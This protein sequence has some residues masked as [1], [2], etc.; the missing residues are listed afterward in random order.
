MAAKHDVQNVAHSSANFWAIIVKLHA[1]KP[2]KF[3]AEYQMPHYAIPVPVPL[4]AQRTGNIYSHS[5]S[6]IPATW[7]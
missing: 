4:P 3:A 5:V 1:S 7:Q 6:L 2:K